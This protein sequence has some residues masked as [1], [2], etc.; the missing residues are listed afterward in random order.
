MQN[1]IFGLIIFLGFFTLLSGMYFSETY[2]VTK[3]ENNTAYL[4][5][6]STNFTL[7]SG[8]QSDWIGSLPACEFARDIDIPI[9][10][11][12]IWGAACIGSYVTWLFQ[13]VF[14]RTDIVWLQIFFIGAAAVIMYAVVRLLRGGG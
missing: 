10:G 2:R 13:L 4:G 6:N 8:Q 14:L 9:L 7:L 3:I 1:A 12:L 11:G 5:Y